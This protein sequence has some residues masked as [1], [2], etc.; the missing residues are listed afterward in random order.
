VKGGEQVAGFRKFKENHFRLQE[1]NKRTNKV[2]P[3]VTSAKIPDNMFVQ[4]PAAKQGINNEQIGDYFSFKEP[5]SQKPIK[6]EPITE[7]GGAP[8][9]VDANAGAVVVT[10]EEGG[11]PEKVDANAGKKGK[12]VKD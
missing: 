3:V 6:N 5:E 4:K 8:E 9:K 10:T 2:A 1:M 7:E 12:N 11:A